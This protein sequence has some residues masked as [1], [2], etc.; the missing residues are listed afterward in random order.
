MQNTLPT[1]QHL[2]VFYWSLN[3]QAIEALFL[4][5][6]FFWTQVISLLMPHTLHLHFLYLY[7]VLGENYNVKG[8]LTDKILVWGNSSSIL[9]FYFILGI[10]ECES[11]QNVYHD[12]IHKNIYACLS[13]KISGRKVKKTKTHTILEKM[14]N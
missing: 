9:Y 14:S 5:Y 8:W 13:M 1:H 12:H 7:L 4:I 2:T 11:L 3:N 10:R 6:K